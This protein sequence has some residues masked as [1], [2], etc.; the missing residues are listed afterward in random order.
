MLAVGLERQPRSLLLHVLHPRVLDDPGH[1]EGAG[2]ERQH[3]QAA[4][5][6]RQH[7]QEAVLVRGLEHVQR[8]LED[9]LVVERPDI[10]RD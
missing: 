3:G 2:Q 6:E 9:V 10:H 8:V 4:G 1:G 5:R 7:R